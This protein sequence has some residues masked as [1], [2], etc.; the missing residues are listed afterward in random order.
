MKIAMF[1]DSWETD[2]VTN[3]IKRAKAGLEGRGHKV[4]V[5]TTTE[6]HEGWQGDFYYIKGYRFP[7]YPAYRTCFMPSDV[8]NELKKLEVDVIHVHTP[9]FVGLKG[10]FIADHNQ[11]PCVF[12]YHTDFQMAMELYLPG[13]KKLLHYL[14]A[15]SLRV[16]LKD[17]TAIIFP[18]KYTK[19]LTVPWLDVDCSQYI[20]PTGVETD[21]FTP[22]DTVF[23]AVKEAKTKGKVLLTLG[24]IARE[25][26]FPLLFKAM[27]HLPSEYVLF[28]GG[29][30]PLYNE[31]KQRYSSD[32]IKFLGYVKDEDLPE[33][34]SSADCFV[35]A[36]KFDTQGMVVAEAMACECPVAVIDYG[37]MPEFVDSSCG[38]LFKEDPKLLA[39]AVMAVVKEPS[40]R[41]GA[42]AMAIK[43]R[44]EVFVEQLEEVYRSISHTQKA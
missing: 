12:T 20:I 13:P 40:L 11:I 38:R 17:F 31:Y 18:S 16:F 24:R 37:A 19:G 26:N 4:Y 32:R 44:T 43:D 41:K 3:S 14:G 23:P 27:D 8:D 6:D 33:L 9:A 2:G 28:V 22:K 30:G 7:F 34:Y 15:I 21:R 25:K 1:T 29:N 36:S 39:K 42:R 35:I 10:M 5:F